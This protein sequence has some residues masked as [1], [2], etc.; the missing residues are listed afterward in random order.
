MLNSKPSGLTIAIVTGILTIIGAASG[1]IIKSY[2]DIAL[3]RT[4]LDSQLI[5]KALKS[6]SLEVRRD[7]LL[8]LVDAN[9]ITNENTAKG[10]KLY[11]EG[12]NP[13]SP[14]QIKTF[15]RSGDSM[16]LPRVGDNL[17]QKTDVDIFVCGKDNTNNKVKDIISKTNIVLSDSMI[18]GTGKLKVWDGDLYEEISLSEL[19]GKTTIIMDFKHGEYGERKSI[20]RILDSVPQ[21]PE[22]VFVENQGKVTPW[23]VSIV[24]CLK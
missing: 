10:L 15:I 22:R 1:S 24:I 12:S 23:R 4:K 6:D 19:R 8:F 11:F 9:L 3:E 7:A 13:K 20:S 2:A 5:L 18:F 17:A 16:P 14:P 21:L